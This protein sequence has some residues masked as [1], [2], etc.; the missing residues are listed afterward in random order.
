MKR[1]ERRSGTAPNFL[2]AA[3]EH[4]YRLMTDHGHLLIPPD[5]PESRGTCWRRR[6]ARRVGSMTIE[7]WH[8]GTLCEGRYRSF[9]I[10]EDTYLVACQRGIAVHPV[11]A[12]MQRT[13]ENR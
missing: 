12:G 9:A 10:A 11:R 4:A 8:S 2:P 7:P 13:G 6:S 5:R 3:R 1:D